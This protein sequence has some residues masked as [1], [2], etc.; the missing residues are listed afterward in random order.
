MELSLIGTIAVAAMV[1]A[2][3]LFSVFYTR[4][5]HIDVM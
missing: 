4:M 2:G 3:T 1:V 5:E